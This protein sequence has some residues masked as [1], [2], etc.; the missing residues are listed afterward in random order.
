M[1]NYLDIYHDAPNFK[2]VT[3]IPI[4]GT[5]FKYTMGGYPTKKLKTYGY[6]GKTI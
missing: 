3:R 4:G 2:A 6:V 1:P 5:K